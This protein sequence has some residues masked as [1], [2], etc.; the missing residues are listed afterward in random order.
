MCIRDSNQTTLL[1]TTMADLWSGQAIRFLATELTRR[2]IV[3]DPNPDR[4]VPGR[5]PIENPRLARTFRT[6]LTHSKSNRLTIAELRNRL[7]AG[8]CGNFRFRHHVFLSLFEQL[9]AAWEDKL[10]REQCIDFED[11]LGLAADCI[12][13]NRLSLIH[14]SGFQSLLRQGREVAVDR[15]AGPRRPLF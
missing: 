12:E 2:G 14:I 11:M 13:Q 5:K 4:P 9:R 15:R 6:F 10:V 7:D 1:E 8:L 3:L